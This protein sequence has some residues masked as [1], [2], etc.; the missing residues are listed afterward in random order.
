[1]ADIFLKVVNMSISAGWIVLAVLLLRILLKKAPKWINVFLWG[2]VGA[3]LV[4]PFSIESVMSLIPSAET[5][6]MVPDAP[7]PH[8]ESGVT[9]VDNQVNDYLQ[10]Y[11]FEGVSR[12]TGHFLDITTILAIAWLIGIAVLLIY[13][14]ISY[15]R[16]RKRVKTAVLYKD[17][18]FQSEN[19][20]SPFVLGIISPKIYL[21]FNMSGQDI[22]HVIAHEQSHIY[23]KDYLWKP[24]GFFILSIH[25]FNPLVWLG[26]V[27]LCRDIELA[28]DERVIKELDTEQ[29]A[30]YSAALLSLSINRRMIAACPIAFG[31]VGV[32][33][34]IKAVLNYKKP[35]FWLIAVAV[36]LSIIA[37]VC[38]LTNPKTM[39]KKAENYAVN[40]YN[41]G[42]KCNDVVYE[43]L[44]GDLEAD[45]PS[46]FV[47]WT[48]NTNDELCFGTQYLIYK[49]NEILKPKSEIA[50]DSILC[51]VKSGKS[52]SENYD[53]S[54][55]E[56]KK[57]QIYTLEKT[58]YLA[59]NPEQKYKASVSFSINETYSFVGKQYA[60]EKVVYENGSYSLI[61]TEDNIPQFVISKPQMAFSKLDAS[62][63][64]WERID[65]LQRIKLEKANF[66]ELFTNEIWD[67]GYS[68]SKIRENNLEAFSAFDLKGRMYYLL[69]QKN[70]DIY[71]AQS[72][73]VTSDFRWLFKM[74]ETQETITEEVIRD[75][76][77]K[78]A[79]EMVVVSDDIGITALQG[80]TDW[81]YEADNGKAVTTVADSM[82]PLQAKKFMP[83][84][85]IVP[86]QFSYDD[87]LSARIQF[88]VKNTKSVRT[89]LPD[90]VYV[91]CWDESCWGNA[92]AKSEEI[93]VNIVNGNFF[94][95]L[96]DGNYIYEVTAHWRSAKKYSG[97]STYS[98]YTVKPKIK[99]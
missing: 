93:K 45:T 29:K 47:K 22:E 88:N 82:H 89:M 42:A 90:E 54:A 43:Y 30:D 39:P 84:L 62:S 80:T 52:K 17:N 68:A 37:G 19:V 25:W 18:I 56:F 51:V 12:P 6:S 23:R 74:R 46:I 91:H 58:F 34:R 65:Y 1:M 76:V 33:N 36:I 8:F 94:F 98:F 48:N 60:G 35:A 55:Y 4:F 87:P 49:D 83:V 15:L 97:T 77:I 92:G 99:S 31:E 9:I 50:F 71:I 85:D 28:C 41:V 79:P 11:Y 70:G 63:N 73:T 2:I 40:C 57:N 75:E 78:E 5:I 38:F 95:K 14:A 59:S 3:R 61:I 67:N 20:A 26:Y 53:L 27:I 10:G 64:S 69:E 24:L 66:D 16:L 21:P 32:K 13:T 86:T 72:G 7:R 81:T 96:K 44:Y